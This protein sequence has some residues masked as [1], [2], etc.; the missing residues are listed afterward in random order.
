MWFFNSFYLGL[1]KSYF[2]KF[3]LKTYVPQSAGSKNHQYLLTD[4]WKLTEILH[5]MVFLNVLF[6]V[7]VLQS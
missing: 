1:L 6:M 5:E 4:N 7:K 2:L 3:A